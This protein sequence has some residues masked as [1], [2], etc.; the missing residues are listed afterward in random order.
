MIRKVIALVFSSVIAS[1][2][3]YAGGGGE[4][5]AT[6]AQEQETPVAEGYSATTVA[7]IN[8]QWMVDGDMLRLRLAA[9]TTGWLAV[10]FEPTKQMKDA[11]IIVG[12]VADGKVFVRDD[13][14]IANVR[15]APDVEHGGRRNI[16]DV[17]GEEVDG[18]TTI[19]FAI[20]LDSGDPLDKVLKPGS[21]YKL[22]ASRGPDGKDDFTT[23]HAERGSGEISL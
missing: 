21:T 9:R 5:G 10:G 4:K 13:F 16:F 15:H 3:L 14:G 22:I 18:V 1:S 7:G 23:Y 11:N 8:I 12:Y 20:P 2:A 19:R 6:T 17:E